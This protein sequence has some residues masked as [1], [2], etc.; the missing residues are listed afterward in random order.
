MHSFI[1]KPQLTMNNY[2][3]EWLIHCI[4]SEHRPSSIIFCATSYPYLLTHR[5]IIH[6]SRPRKIP[7]INSNT[8]FIAYTLCAAKETLHSNS[9]HRSVNWYYLTGPTSLPLWMLFLCN[10]RGS[11]PLRHSYPHP[12]M[13]SSPFTLISLLTVVGCASALYEQCMSV[14]SLF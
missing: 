14:I 1:A 11:L 5:I 8:V 4:S 10:I 7:I 6:W 2:L 9:S 12:T 13:K 3:L